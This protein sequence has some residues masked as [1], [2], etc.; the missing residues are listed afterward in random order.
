MNVARRLTS[1]LALPTTR[2]IGQHRVPLALLKQQKRTALWTGERHGG[3]TLLQGRPPLLY[4]YFFT[5]SYPLRILIVSLFMIQAEIVE[6]V[7]YGHP[8]SDWH[9]KWPKYWKKRI[10][11]FPWGK[12]DALDIYCWKN[13]DPT[14]LGDH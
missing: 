7:Y 4:G 13:V 6:H 11:P 1:R 12:C 5:M 2:S 8:P 10:K 14:K 3:Y 9:E